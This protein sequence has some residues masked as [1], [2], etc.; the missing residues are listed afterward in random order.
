MVA[1]SVI[2]LSSLALLDLHESSQLHCHDINMDSLDPSRLF[3]LGGHLVIYLSKTFSKIRFYVASDG[4]LVLHGSTQSDH[5]PSPRIFK[6]EI[7][8]SPKRI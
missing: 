5:R 3:K 6:P 8:N 4:G 2:D 7:G 1:S